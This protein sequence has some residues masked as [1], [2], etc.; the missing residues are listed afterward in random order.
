MMSADSLS[1]LR[2]DLLLM[3]IEASSSALMANSAVLFLVFR[4]SQISSSPEDRRE[5]DA[6]RKGS[7]AVS[8]SLKDLAFE[9]S[10]LYDCTQL[11]K[12]RPAS[13]FLLQS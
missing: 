7:S 10:L 11:S 13:E 2:L 5:M 4:F 9:R 6:N 3:E 12:A 8:S 1:F